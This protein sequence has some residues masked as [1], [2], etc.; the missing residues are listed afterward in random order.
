MVGGAVPP[1]SDLARDFQ[2]LV[3]NLSS[4]A[5]TRCSCAAQDN[6]AL[7]NAFALIE[8][9]PRGVEGWPPWTSATRPKEHGKWQTSIFRRA[10]PPA[11][12][13]RLVLI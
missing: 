5:T 6:H 4:V 10:Q 7:A 9:Q 2:T 11:P 1:R 12:S 3:L 8:G 13:Y